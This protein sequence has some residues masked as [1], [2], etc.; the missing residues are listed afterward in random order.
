[1]FKKTKEMFLVPFR[2]MRWR[3][4][5]LLMV[6]FAFGAM[7]FYAIPLD[8]WVKEQLGLSAVELTTIGVWV[9][10]PWTIKMV[11]G[12][13][14][15][16][17]A[18]FGSL[19]RSYIFVAAGLMSLGLVLLAGLAGEWQSIMALGS[20]STL[21]LFSSLV[22]TIGLVLQDIVADTMSIEVITREGKSEEVIKKE[23]SE[24][25]LLGRLALYLGLFIFSP[26]GAWVATKVSYE[27]LFLLTLAIPLVSISGSLLVKL[28]KTIAEP[29]RWVVLGGGFIYALF[30][31]VMG[32]LDIP[33]DQEIVFGVSLGIVLYLIRSVVGHVSPNKLRG[34]ILAG[35]ILFV[36]RA[37]P[38]VG[39]GLQWWE[40]DVLGFDKGFFGVL[41]QI[42][43][44][45]AILGMF[46]GAKFIT[47][48]SIGFVLGWIVVITFFLNL[49]IIGM[50][51][52]LHEWTQTHFGFGARTIALVDTAVS[53]PFDQLSMIPMLALAAYYAPKGNVATW[54]A[55]GAS[56]MNLAMTG[57]ALVTKYLNTLFVVTREVRDAAGNISVYADYSHL[58]TL[59]IITTVL[60]LVLPLATI[61]LCQPKI[62]IKVKSQ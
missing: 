46:L 22:I 53:S 42:G 39:P 8:F 62:K 44:G 10:L 15:D 45:I 18:L 20:K 33:Y 7:S 38:P 26:F 29:I 1:M 28:E 31:L 17:V 48:K 25:Q 57:G 27:T 55:L 14:V 50:Y 21:Y 32:N 49:P 4:V 52:G 56:F 3:Y 6:Y 36:F 41:N 23:L 54:M 43:Y 9:S 19:R 60:G 58:G 37:M 34:I 51:Y 40:I 2:A 5:P 16:S 47:Q 12:Q 35:V 61:W 13:M 11:F 59:M 30:V 24:V